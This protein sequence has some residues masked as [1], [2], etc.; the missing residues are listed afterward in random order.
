MNATENFIFKDQLSDITNS[1]IPEL[2]DRDLEKELFAT[3]GVTEIIDALEQVKGHGVKTKKVEAR[4]YNKIFCPN[5]PEDARLL[6]QLLNDKEFEIVMWKDTWTA[7]GDF[8][9]FIIYKENLEFK[10]LK[11][12]D[13]EDESED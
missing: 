8:R 1:S 10:K 9:I 13:D 5:T 3:K 4:V 6:N 7:H 12:E 2:S 11:K